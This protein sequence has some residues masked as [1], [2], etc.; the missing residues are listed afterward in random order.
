MRIGQPQSQPQ[1]NQSVKNGPNHNHNLTKL[2]TP[3]TTSTQF[4]YNPNPIFWIHTTQPQNNFINWYD[5]NLNPN[6]IFSRII[7]P[8]QSNFEWIPQPNHNTIFLPKLTPI[9]GSTTIVTAQ[10]QPQP[11]QQNNHNY[12]WVETM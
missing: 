12:S 2:H 8:T 10:Q 11:Q 7:T 3:T 4:F 1:H 6:T 9:R 5:H